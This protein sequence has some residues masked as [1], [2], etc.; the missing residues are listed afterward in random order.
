MC[1]DLRRLIQTGMNM[2]GPECEL[3]LA[4]AFKDLVAHVVAGGSRLAAPSFT[5]LMTPKQFSAAQKICADNAWPVVNCWGI[6]IDHDA[7]YH[8]LQTRV[9]KDGCSSDE[10]RE[11]LVKAYG[12]N[13]IVRINRQRGA[14]AL[15]L[16][17]HQRVTVGTSSYYSLAV[18]EVRTDGHRN[19]L[20]PVTAYHAT[21]A[22]MRAIKR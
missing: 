8:P 3:A 17:A 6:L 4:H 1:H 12:P 14:Q 2:F 5:Y 20:A 19:Y 7:I 13:S 22:K 9:A 11:I 18:L 16:N 21:E 15:L 10:V